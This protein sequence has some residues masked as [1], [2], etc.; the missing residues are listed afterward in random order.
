MYRCVAFMAAILVT[1]CSAAVADDVSVTAA[2]DPPSAAVGE[3]VTYEVS[4]SVGGTSAISANPQPQLPDLKGF[5]I[6]STGTRRNVIME[7]NSGL[8]VTWGFIYRLRAQKPG[9]HALGPATVS[10]GDRTYRSNNVMINVTPA[11]TLTPPSQPR[12]A[13]PPGGPPESPPAGSTAQPAQPG[14]YVPSGPVDLVLTSDTKRPYVGQ[15]VTL[16]FTFYRS[17]TLAEVS[18]EAPSAQDFVLKELQ[19]PDPVERMYGTTLFG[20]HQRRWAAFATGS[21]QRRVQPVTVTL[22][23]TPYDSPTRVQTNPLEIDVRP[24]PPA[25]QGK[26]FEGAVGRFAVS[27]TTDR[28]TVKTGESFTL[29]IIVRGAGNI[30]A[31]GVPEPK[32][33][34]SAKVYRSRDDRQSAPGYNGDPD[35]VG[36]EARFDFLILPKQE[37]TLTIPG[38]EYL[39][40]NPQSKR[41]ET[42]RAPGLS[43][44]VKPGDV[45]AAPDDAAEQRIRHIIPNGPGSRQTHPPFANRLLWAAQIIPL[46]ALCLIGYRLR[47]ADR[48]RSDP[49]LARSLNA[50]RVARAH[51]QAARQALS[52]NDGD[53]FCGCVYHAVTDYIAQRGG[54]PA[55][56]ISSSEALAALRSA[57]ADEALLQ[58]VSEVLRDCDYGR[59]AGGGRERFDRMLAEAQAI[60]DCIRTLDL[61][62]A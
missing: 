25:P 10:I 16:T 11:P 61:R 35:L 34:P 13:Y 62:K 2:A 18:Y 59:F 32:L 47:R 51:L 54:L 45:M 43:V 9:S 7:G 31:L 42:A 56:D 15:Q 57:G 55:R 60:I 23:M 40:F 41:Y 37:G 14:E 19:P 22:Q 33:P 4:V 28:D 48:L 44:Q 53:A 49:D 12:G 27:M 39:F 26:S 3:M 17:R 1:V 21:G 46:I 20:V 8:Q 38:L 30:H 24:L 5:E 36:G 29:S 50:P 52:D 6:L 58:R